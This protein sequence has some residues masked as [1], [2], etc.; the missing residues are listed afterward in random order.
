MNLYGRPAPLRL[1]LFAVNP[2][3]P[4]PGMLLENGPFQSAD[5]IELAFQFG[6][7]GAIGEVAHEPAHMKGGGVDPNE[8]SE[9]HSLYPPGEPK[10]DSNESH[11]IA[12]P[13]P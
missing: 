11:G 9:V 12:P 3:D 7:D 10:T 4:G 6:L 2:I 8:L 13:G 5:L 1:D